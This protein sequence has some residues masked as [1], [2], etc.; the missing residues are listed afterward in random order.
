MHPHVHLAIALSVG[1]L[2]ELQ[3]EEFLV[4]VISSTIIDLD[5]VFTSLTPYN[6][7]NH[8]LFP[9][10]W[11]SL[12]V[13]ITFIGLLSH[14]IFWIGIGG[15]LHLMLD[16]PDW[17][18]PVFAPVS[19]KLSPHLLSTPTTDSSHSWKW[20]LQKYY[21][22]KLIVLIEILS[23]ILLLGLLLLHA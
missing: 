15:F 19:L 20:F 4:F 23:M 16:L 2:L 6:Y 7:K 22:N 18:L 14:L 10:H 1:F 9:S 21:E 11:I 8:R 13:G 12:W 3:S 5:I 17:G